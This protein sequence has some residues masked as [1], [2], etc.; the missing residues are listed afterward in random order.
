M[1]PRSI[2]VLLSWVSYQS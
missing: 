1:T 2:Y